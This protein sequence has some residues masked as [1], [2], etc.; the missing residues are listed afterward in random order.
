MQDPHVSQRGRLVITFRGRGEEPKTEDCSK[1][2][3][4]SR[5]LSTSSALAERVLTG[6]GAERV[7]E[8]RGGAGRLAPGHGLPVARA[9][10]R[11]TDARPGARQPR[12]FLAHRP[13]ICPSN[14]F[15]FTD[16]I[17]DC[18]ARDWSSI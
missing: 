16:L 8:E 9:R 7:E 2:I 1:T 10:R 5:T 3:R 11:R 15:S 12:P 14:L 18:A 13:M 6:D 17:R 4:S